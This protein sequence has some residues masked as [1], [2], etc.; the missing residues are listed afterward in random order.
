[1]K[2]IPKPVIATFICFA[3]LLAGLLLLGNYVL[4]LDIVK[5]NRAFSV[6][7][8]NKSS[9]DLVAVETGL[10]TSDDAGKTIKV[11]PNFHAE[12][13]RS[14]TSQHIKPKLSSVGEGGIYLKFTN[15]NGESFER[16]VCSY[17]E[18]VTGYT[19]VKVTDK[20]IK[21]DESCY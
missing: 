15:S 18:H 2:R 20:E 13:I 16:S 9:Y 3:A 7:I 4:Q 17:T 5:E 11:Q 6:R 19:K 8:D 1:M 12:P 21:V 14:G 10:L